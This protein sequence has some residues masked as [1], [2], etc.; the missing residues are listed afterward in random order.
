MTR[1]HHF[2]FF[3]LA[4][5]AVSIPVS[6]ASPTDNYQGK[7]VVI[8]IGDD[9]LLSKQS[10]DYMR[11]VV[12]KA[13]DTGAAAI[14]FELNTPGGLA[15][16][17][18]DLMKELQA[19][20]VPSYAF[21][22]TKAIS[23]GALISVACDRIYMAPG[24]IIGAAAVVDSSGQEMDP[25]MRKKLDSAFTAMMRSVVEQKGHNIDLVMCM[26]VAPSETKHFGDITVKEGELLSLSAKEAVSLDQDGKP[27][28]A[29][30]IAHSIEELMEQEGIT[31]P[32]IHANPTGFEQIAMWIGIISPFLI[33]IG[34]GGIYFEFK[35]PGFGIG[36]IIAI[37][38]F[39]LFFFGNNIAG[40]L[41]GYETAALFVLGVILIIVEVFF[42]PGT[43]IAGIVGV[44]LVLVALFSGMLNPPDLDYIVTNDDWSFSAIVGLGVKPMLQLS[45]GLVGAA[46]LVLVLMRYLPETSIFRKFSNDVISGGE[47]EGEAVTIAAP[48]SSGSIGVS[49]TELKPNGKALFNGET[50]EVFSR[51]GIL[52]KGTALRVIEKRAFDFVVEKADTAP[53]PNKTEPEQ[54]PETEEA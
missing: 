12:A 40:N 14:I 45:L 39:G 11:R 33:L 31:A 27:I 47:D 13:N 6:N 37:V 5:L 53:A 10:F 18:T 28:L 17:T 19:M 4:L 7:A 34:I 3:L 50:Y 32:V 52:P 21:V 23:A 42:I 25:V 20:S 54:G 8:K 22:N 46:I 15:M 44:I 24:A 51:D 43:F 1:L 29:Q 30:G 48:L 9:S 36:G 26:M 41:A 2:V 38:A 35:T 49:M 16:D